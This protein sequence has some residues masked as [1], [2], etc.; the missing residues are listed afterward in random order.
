MK[1]PNGDDEHISLECQIQIL[2]NA[3]ESRKRGL[4]IWLIACGVFAILVSVLSVY[5][6]SLFFGVVA[7]FGWFFVWNRWKCWKFVRSLSP[8]SL[9]PIETERSQ[10]IDTILKPI[11]NPPLWARVSEYLAAVVLIAM[12]GVV[13]LVVVKT[14]GIWLRVLYGLSWAVI[15]LTI[16]LSLKYARSPTQR[17]SDK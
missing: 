2:S 13:T 3:V 14:S 1:K 7:A 16:V 17:R 10:W 6:Q 11:Q 12:F 9:L 8:K 15:V 5:T 4:E